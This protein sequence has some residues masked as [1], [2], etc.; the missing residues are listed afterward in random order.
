M[1]NEVKKEDITFADSYTK[2]E[3]GTM[4]TAEVVAFAESLNFIEDLGIKNIAL[5]EN[6]ILQYGLEKLKE[7]ILLI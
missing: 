1:I 5:H 6:E 2:F 4:Q 7:T 3:A